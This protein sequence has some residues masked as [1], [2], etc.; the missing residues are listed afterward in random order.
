MRALQ[1]QLSFKSDNATF[2][3]S[4][5]SSHQRFQRLL[6]FIVIEQGSKWALKLTCKNSSQKCCCA[7]CKMK[8][9]KRH[10]RRTLFIS[11]AEA[12]Q[13]FEKMCAFVG[14][15]VVVHST[16]DQT[17]ATLRASCQINEL[18]ERLRSRD[19]IPLPVAAL[20]TV[21]FTTIF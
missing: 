16:A 1:K 14:N 9:H 20:P 15:S 7:R 6:A 5:Q 17:E 21:C 2:F 18:L 12:L 4:F 8:T 3:G 19:R 10:G 13:K 11:F